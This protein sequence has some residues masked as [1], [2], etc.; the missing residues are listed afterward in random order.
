MK[1]ITTLMFVLM[2]FTSFA[3][4]IEKKAKSQDDVYYAPATKNLKEMSAL[5]DKDQGTRTV[6]CLE[7]FRKER[8]TAYAIG[9]I[10]AL[11]TSLSPTFSDQNTRNIA[12]YAGG[13]AL[14]VSAVLFISADRWLSSD[15]LLIGNNGISFRF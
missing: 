7:H 4:K 9:I 14:L 15:R 2:V 10:G 5:A 8:S 3:Q 13:G 11:A 6:Y 12:T 1:T